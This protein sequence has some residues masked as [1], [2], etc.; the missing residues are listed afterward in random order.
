MDY[1]DELAPESLQAFFQQLH[2]DAK[3]FLHAK[4]PF[5]FDAYRSNV[6]ALMAKP[7]PLTGRPHQEVVDDIRTNIIPGS[8][9]QH[10]KNYIAF[11]DKGS[12]VSAQYA[13]MLS[14]VMNQ[15]L[16]A[17]QK[18]APTGTYVEM[19]V[20][21]WLRE[22]VGYKVTPGIPRSA[23]DLGGAVV[24]GG[25]LANTIGLLGA[26]QHA[27][28]QSKSRGMTAFEKTP[29]IFVAGSTMSHYSH[30]GASWWLGF[31]TDNVIEVAC[32]DKGTMDQ[33]D[34]ERKLRRSREVGE[35]PVAVMAVMGDSRMNTLEDL[36]G[37][38]RICQNFDVWLHVDAC[39]GGVLAFDRN[40]TFDDKH[41]LSYSDS[42][43]IDPHKHLGV[44]Y[45]GSII[46]FKDP[47]RMAAIGTSTDITIS[48]GSAD[49]GQVTPFLASRAF[50][51]LKIY[52]VLTTLGVD[53]IHRR[54]QGRREAVK[55]W[56]ALLAK[57]PSLMPLHEPD[58]VAQ[59]FSLRPGGMTA[60]ELSDKNVQLHDQLYRDG[61][62]VVN[63]FNLR[64]YG[65]VM[66]YGRGAKV[67]CLGSIFG[68]DDYSHDDLLEMLAVL[69]QT[70]AAV[71]ARNQVPS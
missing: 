12:Y 35:L 16:V 7:L 58:L 37:L 38:H 25:V 10:H 66:P 53:G 2:D 56:H 49:I 30:H 28:P 63:K 47:A 11:P 60:S 29:K 51:A 40:A 55:R 54:I 15:N 48:Y 44:P 41:V 43:A 6:D 4:K 34:L 27:C 33:S 32:N 14:D 17:D 18:S 21:S 46:L 24:T 31:G 39:H 71:L 50:D 52:A 13:A 65:S 20:I 45:A 57:S 22:L 19:L 59:A 8:I 68:G 36:P 26:R 70:A 61:D 69:E 64:D 62:V 67:T 23:H 42:I 5:D 1:L 3:H 9:H